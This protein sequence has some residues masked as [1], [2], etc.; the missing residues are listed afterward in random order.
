MKKSSI[1]KFF[2]VTVLASLALSACGGSSSETAAANTSA[3]NTAASE[4]KADASTENTGASSEGTAAADGVRT[5]VVSHSTASWPDNALTA[6]GESDGFEVAVLKAID[7][8]LPQYEFKFEP[9]GD[10]SD[11]LIG[12]QTG[13]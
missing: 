11:L 1:N 4:E 12:V 2:A 10:D 3:E 5:I 13:K 7:E 8:L 6:D 9:T